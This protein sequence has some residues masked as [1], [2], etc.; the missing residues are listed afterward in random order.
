M[1]HENM[2]NHHQFLQSSAGTGTC[3]FLYF[4]FQSESY[5]YASPKDVRQDNPIMCPGRKKLATLVKKPDNCHIE[6]TSP[7]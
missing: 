3:R 2:V 7:L 6:V 4:I 5:G 1:A